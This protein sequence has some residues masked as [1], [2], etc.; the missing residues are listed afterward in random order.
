MK[1]TVFF[2]SILITF[3]LVTACGGNKSKSLPCPN[4]SKPFVIKTS[5]TVVPA[6]TV[7]GVPEY[8]IVDKTQVD[9]AA[10]PK[11]KDGYIILF[12]GKSLYGWR[13]YNMNVVPK[14]WV[15]DEAEGAL[16]FIGTGG[17]EAQEADGGDIIF[18]YKFKNF[19]LAFDWKVSKGSNSGVFYLAREIKDIPIW[20]SSPEYQI[21]DNANHV[22]AKQGIDGNRQSASLYDMIPAK[23]QNALPYGQWNTGAIT[24]YKGSVFHQ[25]N[26][27]TVLEYHLWIPKWNEMIANSKFAPKGEFPLAYG[28][29][30][31]LGGDNREGYIGFQ[32]HGDDVWF[33]NIRIKI[34]D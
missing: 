24:V 10:F 33:R 19:E 11:D 2:I 30:T 8:I 28:F 13:G 1:K 25:Q 16:K 6:D 27:R 20:Q 4:E 23:P 26:G 34:L 31:K 12:C 22:D 17:G 14:R 15:I 21:L 18:S 7:N 9:L 5:E 29:L 32:D 3:G